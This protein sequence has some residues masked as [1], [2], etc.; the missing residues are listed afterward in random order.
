MNYLFLTLATG[1]VAIALALLL[2]P[3]LRRGRQSGERGPA[4]A[5]ALLVALAL[6][7]AAGATYL[8]IG[9]PRALDGVSLAPQQ[10]LTMDEALAQLRAHLAEKPDDVTGWMLLGQ[11]LGT[12]HQNAEARDAFDHVLELDANSVEAMV[13]WAE[14]DAATHED[15]AIAGRA[16]ELL[17]R[18]VKL[19]PD[20]QRGLWLLGVSDFQQGD[21]AGAAATWRILAPQLEPGSGVARTIAGQIAAAEARAGQAPAGT[22]GPGL[23]VE[24]SLAPALKAKLAPDATLY[25]YARAENGRASCRERVSVVV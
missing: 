15:H 10:P 24:V 21:Y 25:V 17:L 9:T 14:A 16:R 7:L 5:T 11:T 13:G 12:L 23:E 18:A 20:S 4:F 22:S 19:Q 6:P 8:A 3:L 2:V 1:M